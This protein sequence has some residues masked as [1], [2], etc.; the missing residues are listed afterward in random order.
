M[1]TA[2]DKIS[3]ILRADK[4]FLN[5]IERHLSILTGKTGVMEKIVEDNDNLLKNHLL[6]LGVSGDASA[7]EVY[8]ALISKV[9]ADDHLVFEALGLSLIHI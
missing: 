9:E 4:G 8:D 6:K 7:K 5:K 3:K 1:T 2:V